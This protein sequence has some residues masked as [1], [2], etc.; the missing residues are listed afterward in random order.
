MAISQREARD[1]SA[2]QPQDLVRSERSGAPMML[3]SLR[4]MV[5][6]WPQSKKS[7]PVSTASAKPVVEALE[8]RVVPSSGPL[9]GITPYDGH[10]DYV[11]KIYECV[12]HRQA[13]PVGLTGWMS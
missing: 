8:D 2:P 6:R 1:A 3:E 13:D 5:R 9:Y 11:E 10:A 12:L 7:T 4:E